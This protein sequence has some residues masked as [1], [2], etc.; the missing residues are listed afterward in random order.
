MVY[1]SK[2]RPLGALRFL[3]V[4]C[5]ANSVDN[6]TAKDAKGAKKTR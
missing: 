6:S 4:L 1:H 5:G 3:C 2:I